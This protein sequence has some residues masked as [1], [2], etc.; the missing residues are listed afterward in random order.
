MCDGNAVNHLLCGITGDGR[1]MKNVWISLL[2]LAVKGS[3]LELSNLCQMQFVTS[4][5]SICKDTLVR[6][7]TGALSMFYCH[8]DSR[9]C[10]ITWI[11]VKWWVI[12]I[13]LSAVHTVTVKNLY[14]NYTTIHGWMDSDI[15]WTLE[16]PRRALH[17]LHRDKQE[18]KWLI[19]W[20]IPEHD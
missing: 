5:V 16:T 9:L 3:D 1:Q 8:E 15:M 14:H 4:L 20:V 17:F 2:C 10:D 18:E 11:F 7:L 6:R 13:Y 19:W 12:Y